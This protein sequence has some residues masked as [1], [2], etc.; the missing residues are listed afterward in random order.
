MRERS[1]TRPWST[2]QWPAGLWPPPRTAI[3]RPPGLA[4]G[5]RRRHVLDIDAAGDRRRPPVDQQ[6]EAEAS[7]LVLTVAFDQ[8]V[9]RQRITQLLH[10]LS[11]R[12]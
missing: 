11:Y 1:I 10:G 2:T 8:D 6:V 12:S 9:A 4:E 7:P 5:K 3:S